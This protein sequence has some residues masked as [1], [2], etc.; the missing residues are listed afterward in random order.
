MALCVRCY[1]IAQLILMTAVLMH[2]L[3]IMEFAMTYISEQL[4][5]TGLAS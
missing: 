4:V 5:F 1:N 2:M 3:V